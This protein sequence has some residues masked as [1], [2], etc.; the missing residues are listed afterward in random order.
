M[1][2]RVGYIGLGDMGGAMAAQ[3]AP[4]GLDA[5]V[6]DLNPVPMKK[7]AEAGAT[8]GASCREVGAHAEILSICVPADAHV[9]AV[10]LGEDGA[11][12]AVAHARRRVRRVQLEAA[13]RR[14]RRLHLLVA[15]SV[16]SQRQL[17]RSG[18]ERPRGR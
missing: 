14:R 7:L 5:C 13:G 4:G 16:E 11:L 3:L 15:G 6:F 12:A 2:T 1:A 18:P 10:L 9:E 17:D 8:A